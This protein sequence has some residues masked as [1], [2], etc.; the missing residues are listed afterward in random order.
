MVVGAP[1][2]GSLS[3]ARGRKLTF[4]AA[5]VLIAVFGFASAVA[6]NFATLIAFRTLVG[7]AV[8]GAVVSFGILLGVCVCVLVTAVC[9]SSLCC[10]LLF[11][12]CNGPPHL[13]NTQHTTHH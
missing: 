5:V 3:D 4:G 2:W 8:P 6:P 1:V 10:C 13:P 12:C 7:F 9:A 11:A